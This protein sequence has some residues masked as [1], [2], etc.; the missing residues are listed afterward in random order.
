MKKQRELTAQQ[1]SVW[2]LAATSAPLSAASGAGW[3]AVALAGL[4][5]L[6]L[7][8][9][10]GRGWSGI[11]GATAVVEAIWL[12]LVAGL[13]LQNSAVFWPGSRS[14]W[15]VPLVLTMLITLTKPEAA[16]RAGAVVGLCLAALYVPV[17]VGGAAQTKVE[18]LPAHPGSW[19]QTLLLAL[20]LPSLWGLWREQTSGVGHTL[21]ATAVLGILF[22][23]LVQG[24]LSP[25]VAQAQPN[26]FY[27]ASRTLRLGV[28][29]R[30]EPVA[31]VATTLGWYALGSL[32]HSTA[33]CLA[34][35]GGICTCKAGLGS[36]MITGSAAI[37]RISIPGYLTVGVSLLLWVLVPFLAEKRN[38]KKSE[39]RC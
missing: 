11:G 5:M 23:A 19:T 14:G 2:L 33:V 28:L 36:A 39:K 20:L 17:L 26:A 1:M 15:F 4:A 18:W 22:A 27:E 31:A 25:A 3:A 6:P 38:F 16:P 29:S 9:L 12:S 10:S 7:T 32:L 35:Q 13:M 21:T 24:I 34:K 30:I 37:W 8:C